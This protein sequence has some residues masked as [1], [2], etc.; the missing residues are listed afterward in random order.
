MKN[1]PLRFMLLAATIVLVEAACASP[2]RV[3]PPEIIDS[4]QPPP[5]IDAVAPLSCKE[6]KSLFT[7]DEN[8]PLDIQEENRRR[9]EGVTVIEFNYASPLGG[10]VPAILVVPDGKALFAGLVFMHGSGG[11]R[12]DLDEVAITYARLGAVGITISGPSARP[13]HDNLI[14][15]TFRE[16]DRREQIQ[17]IVDLRRAVDV[18][19]SR[20]EIDPQRLAYIGTSYGGAMGGLLSAVE[21]RLRGYALEVGDGGLVN[22]FNGAY[23]MG[24]PKDVRREWLTAMW[25]IEPIHYV[26]CAAPAALLFQNGTKDTQVRPADAL[27]YQ[28]AGSEP[29]TVQWYEAGHSLAPQAYRDQAEW[30]SDLIG[31]ANYRLAFPLRVQVILAAWFLLTAGSLAFLVLDLWRTRQ[32]PGGAV[33]L[34]FLAIAFLGPLGLAAYWLAYRQSV[35]ARE[36]VAPRSSL[37]CAFGSAAWATAGTMCGVV[38]VLSLILYIQ[39]ELGNNPVPLV[40]TMVLIPLCVNW[41]I[42]AASRWLSRSAENFSKTYHCPFLI[43][44]VSSILVLVGAYPLLIELINRN[45]GPWTTWFVFDLSYP[46]LWGSLSLAALAGM[47]ITYPFHLWM[48]RRGVIRWGITTKPA[49]KVNL[50]PPIEIGV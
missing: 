39:P 50:Q 45:F 46:P 12:W 48:I 44:M 36:L 4:W 14:P 30:L 10:R 23:V 49:E 13:E 6:I 28:Q 2:G 43:G 7:Y 8:A 40:A 5:D 1:L 38:V 32:A 26:G 35:K 9:V 19:L 25:P 24:L 11:S 3:P 17:L 18:L 47:L 27:R 22:H 20:P 34:W 15:F 42:I 41:L 16:K 33:L 21:P 31:I 37:R 29:K